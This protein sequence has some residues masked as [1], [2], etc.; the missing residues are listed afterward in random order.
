[1]VMDVPP[2]IPIGHFQGPD[3]TRQGDS[4]FKAFKWLPV[5]IQPSCLAK[6]LKNEFERLKAIM[7]HCMR[8]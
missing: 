8:D 2:V 7:G 6:T 1:M 3:S 5:E 4:L